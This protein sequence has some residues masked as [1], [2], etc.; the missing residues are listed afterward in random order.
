VSPGFW[1]TDLGQTGPFS[2]PAPAGSASVSAT[3]VGRL[4]DPAVASDGG[5]IWQA[6]VD[7]PAGI[8]AA[9]KAN[10]AAHFLDGRLAQG[11]AAP[12]A[13]GPAALSPTPLTLQPGQSGT[14]MATVTPAGPP[15]TVV[16]GD[17]FIDSFDFFTDAGDELTN[18]PYHYTIK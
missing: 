17:L 4:F 8:A 10:L 6:G 2:G 15:G 12:A 18:L 14:I 16:S 3:S 9:A 7:S 13:A 1:E 5:D 11:A